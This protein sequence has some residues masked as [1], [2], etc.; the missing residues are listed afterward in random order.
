MKGH[1]QVKPQTS[2]RQI[3]VGMMALALVASTGPLV[4]QKDDSSDQRTRQVRDSADPPPIPLPKPRSQQ[5]RHNPPPPP[6]G[7]EG[8]SSETAL[9]DEFRRIDGVGNNVATPVL[10]SSEQPYDRLLRSD[11]EDDDAPSGAD[12]PSARAI[13]NA[14]CAQSEL[15][16]NRR[17]ATDF[18]WQWGQFVDHDINETPAAN[19]AEMFNI[20]VP[21]GDP[22][23]DPQGTGTVE[24]PLNRSYCEDVDGVR[25]Q[26]NDITAFIDASNVY[27]STEE[28][29]F[30]VRTLDGSGRLKTTPTKNGDLL[31]YNLPG[32]ANAPTDTPNFFLA[33]D[34]R[35]NE[36]VALTAMHTLFL[37]EHNQWADRYVE[38]N[39]SA[40]G[41]EIYQFARLIV[42][43]EMQVITYREFLPV[44]LGPD[45]IPPYRGYRPEVDPT[46]SN[47]FAAGAYRLGHSLLSPDLLRLDAAGNEAEEGHLSLAAAFFNPA[48]LEDHGIESVLRGL[49]GQTCQE[50]DGKLVDDVRNFLFGPPGSGGFDLAA[51]NIQRGRDHG[52][53]SFNSYCRQLGIRPARTFRDINPD[54]EVW[55]VMASVYDNVNQ[56]DCWIGG[57][58]EPQLR[59]A[60][61]GPMNHKV[62]VDQFTRLRDGDRFWHQNH[63]P[64]ELVRLVEGQ[65]LAVIIRRNTKIGEELPD[66]VFL[67]EGAT[68]NSKPTRGG[69]SQPSKREP[70][71]RSQR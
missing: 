64:P 3:Q 35:A 49:A 40:S 59:G 71:R 63:L 8:G 1:T 21:A 45:A 25:E 51:L 41:E 43:A 42:G 50:L 53:P 28:R 65:S 14:L 30:A 31:P 12:R 15:T 58:C 22:W 27:G 2:P 7:A 60:M 5:S 55:Q 26:F 56:V 29:A 32:L 62:L 52:L 19:P 70:T 36:Q 54:P 33:G 66:N 9:P 44:L 13:S 39:P 46:I 57:L 11:Y 47:V 68:R 10:G 4:A 17:G 38:M 61:V 18:L 24:I 67:A 16:P 34:V 20:Q 37:R 6:P 48:H 69:E 23:F